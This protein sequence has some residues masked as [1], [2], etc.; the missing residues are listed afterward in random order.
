[1]L[2]TKYSMLTNCCLE[3]F[4]LDCEA[5][6]GGIKE[7]HNMKYICEIVAPY[8]EVGATLPSS[9]DSWSPLLSSA[10]I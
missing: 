6:V 1:M 9:E 5:P 3:I 2:E 10:E 7:G 8:L 4:E